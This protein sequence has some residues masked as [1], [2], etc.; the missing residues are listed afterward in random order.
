MTPGQGRKNPPL[1]TVDRALEVLLSFSDGRTD[2]GV[3]ELAA[4]F[5]LDKSSAQRI[6]AALAARGFLRSDPVTRRYSLGPAMWQMA[7]LWER[8]GGL[9]ALARPVL[10]T[11]AHDTRRNAVF[12]VP[13]GLHLR[14]VA[15]VDGSS[16]LRSHSL[17]GELYPANAGATSRAYFAFLERGER[18]LLMRGRIFA[19]F[20]TL[21]EADNDVL[22]RLFE[23]TQTLG[24]A[25]SEG[26]YDFTT[27][28][29][30]VPIYLRGRPIGSLS[31]GEGK[32]STHPD[33]LLDQLPPLREGALALQAL[34]DHSTRAR[35]TRPS[36]T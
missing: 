22:E 17:V 8:T 5:D 27:R 24:Y 20:T 35:A 18:Q 16:P 6:L 15:A 31:L 10:E 34:L 21:T 9:A 7:S 2:W 26:E 33:T 23:D 4:A 14:C 32:A 28:A 25:Y 29:L 13:D 30:A 3:L 19:R 12:A 11:L 36:T 1:Q